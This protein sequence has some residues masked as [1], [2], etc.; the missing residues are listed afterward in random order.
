VDFAG[1]LDQVR[2]QAT[3]M[4][5]AAVAAGP[6]ADVPTCPNWTVHKLVR[7]TARVHN[8]A[9]KAVQAKPGDTAEKADQP[10]EE[11]DALLAWWD[12]QLTTLLGELSGAG[13]DAPAWGFT[14]TVSTTGAF[15]ARRQAHETAIHRLDAEHAS[16][17]SGTSDSLPSLVFDPEF[18]ADGIDEALVIMVPRMLARNPTD[19]EGTV[20]FHAADAGRAWLVRLSPGAAPEVGPAEEPAIDADATVVG[21]ADAVYRAV[22]H[23]PSGAVV[24]GN[25][26]LVDALRTP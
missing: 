16:A 1:F 21:T 10:P 8:W 14:P 17:G 13:P 2:T 18:A 11:W 7:H 6:A 19:A 3:A 15:W 9:V 25:A 5:A 23:R 20:L 24:N 12:A 4:R 26:A 22:W